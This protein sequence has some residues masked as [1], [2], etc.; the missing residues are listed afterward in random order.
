MNFNLKMTERQNV[1]SM[2]FVDKKWM[3]KA[4]LSAI[5]VQATEIEKARA[6]ARRALKQI[7]TRED[8]EKLNVWI[9]LLNLENI[10][11]TPVCW[12]IN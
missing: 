2:A 9:S 4:A 1:H 7:N 6:V 3:Y 10:Y 8:K 5:S 12:N 11:G